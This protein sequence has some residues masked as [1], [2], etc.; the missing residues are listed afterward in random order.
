MRIS[1]I[2]LLLAP[3]AFASIIDHP[4]PVPIF[5][6][7]CTV[8]NQPVACGG[9]YGTE[10]V[11]AGVHV[12][13]IGLNTDTGL[14]IDADSEAVAGSFSG[15]ISMSL[16][17]SAI[18]SASLD[19]FAATDGPDRMG[20]ASFLLGTDG[21]NSGGVVATESVFAQGLGSCQGTLCRSSGKLVPFELGVSFEIGLS[22][23]AN[24]GAG[25]HDYGGSSGVAGLRLHLFEADG[26]TPV[27]IFDPPAP[28]SVP[29]PRS[30]L[31]VGMG[32]IGLTC[33]KL[34]TAS[35]NLE[36][37][38]GSQA[39]SLLIISTIALLLFYWTV[40]KWLGLVLP[41]VF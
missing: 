24:G 22:T 27:V 17:S 23:F 20:F 16:G 31:L 7:A 36:R 28:A 30:V 3:V 15:P 34:K 5:S 40:A 19:F 37:L 18:A 38:S 10:S 35:C 33:R 8:A 41:E 26:L 11:S 29:E 39:T 12:S 14:F 25:Q 2:A 4:D 13:V 21:E 32:L 1:I 6:T 9:Q